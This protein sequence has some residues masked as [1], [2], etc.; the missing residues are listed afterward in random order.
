MDQTKNPSISTNFAGAKICAPVVYFFMKFSHR[1]S[2]LVPVPVDARAYV[3]LCGHS[4]AGIAGSNP[5]AGMIV[6]CEC[7]VLLVGG[8]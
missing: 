4:F 2:L 8:H 1:N 5:A 7:C 6:S 3:W